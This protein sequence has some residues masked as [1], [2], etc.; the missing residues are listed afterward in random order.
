MKESIEEISRNLYNIS[1]SNFLIDYRIVEKTK[2]IL[3]AR[4]HFSEELF[5]QFYVN[6]RRH[7]KSY[8]LILNDRRIFGK[9]Y[10]FGHWH[11]HPFE[12]PEEH[13]VSENGK[14]PA[15]MEEFV[16]ESIFIVSEKLKA[17]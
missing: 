5:L 9:D 11:R 17:I 10:I 3:K 4:L 6:T 16:T 14:K 1:A 8:A 13:D 15:T 7:K 12:N 2:S